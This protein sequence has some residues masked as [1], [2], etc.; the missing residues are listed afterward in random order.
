MISKDKSNPRRDI[1][2]K[3]G[4][5]ARQTRK[6]FDQRIE[7]TGATRSQWTLL[8]VVSGKPGAT[9]RMIAEILE[10][11]EAS[12]GRLIDRLCSEGLLE[13]RAKEDDRRAH[14]VYI[15]ENAAP[16]LK[17][18]AA[19]GAQTEAE[20]FAGLS[21]DELAQLDALLARIYANVTSKPGNPP[22]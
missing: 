20:T 14:C 13:R 22:K 1:A 11:S 8:A 3:I 21:D 9:Q 12:V 10:M 2:L 4:V 16:L 19:V 7:E 6:A 18:M 5:I 15:S 17:Q